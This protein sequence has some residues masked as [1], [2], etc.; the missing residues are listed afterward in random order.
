MSSFLTDVQRAA[1]DA[2]LAEKQ[3]AASKQPKGSHHAPTSGPHAG[4]KKPKNLKGSGASKKGGGGGKFTWGSLLEGEDGV[5]ALDRNDPN[6][7]SD[8]ERAAVLLQASGA[9]Q[10][11][12]QAEVAAYKRGVAAIVEEFFSSGD[13]GNVA[14]SLGDLAAPTSAMGHYFVK[15]LLTLA[16]DRRD[17]E[18]EMASALLS[19]LY[20]EGLSAEQLQKGFANTVDALADLTLDVPDAVELLARVFRRR[21]RAGGGGAPARA[22]PAR[23]A[24]A[25]CQAGGRLGDG[26]PRPRARDGEQPLGRAAPVRDHR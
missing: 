5:T 21:R 7:D 15:R 20:G 19:G 13:V 8:E 2:A 6:Y 26:P 16:M 24:P 9:A 4:D 1:L 3:A 12:L 25:V 17:K 10:G 11:R 14:A 23:P 22:Q 18:R